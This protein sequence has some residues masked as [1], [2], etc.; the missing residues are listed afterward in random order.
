MDTERRTETVNDLLSKISRAIGARRHDHARALL[1]EL[2]GQ[3][4]DDDPEV[5]RIRTLL[6]FMTDDE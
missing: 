2:V 5:T 3:L 1:T 4:G 6:D